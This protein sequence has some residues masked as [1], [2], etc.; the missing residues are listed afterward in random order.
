MAKR[1]MAKRNPA[2]VPAET[3]P[4]ARATGLTLAEWRAQQQHGEPKVLPNSLLAVRLRRCRLM[5]LVVQGNVPQT[6]T[7]LAESVN[8]RTFTIKDAAELLPLINVTVKACQL[9]PPVSPAQ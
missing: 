8:G 1:N 2:D 4:T 7:A 3:A 5:D 6:L 9:E